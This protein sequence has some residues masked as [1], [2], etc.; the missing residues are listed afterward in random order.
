MAN[1]SKVTR[2][3]LT[4]ALLRCVTMHFVSN[5]GGGKTKKNFKRLISFLCCQTQ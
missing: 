1:T 5:E 3:N 4:S 2:R